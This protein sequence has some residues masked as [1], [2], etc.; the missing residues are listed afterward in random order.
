M[1]DRY[2]I[3]R[4]SMSVEFKP[5]DRDLLASFSYFDEN[6]MSLLNEEKE[7][8]KSLHLSK[9]KVSDISINSKSLKLKELGNRPNSRSKR[10]SRRQ[11]IPS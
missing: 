11:N 10:Y 7:V 8:N 1:E 4:E 2:K 5:I 9:R 6:K 3:K